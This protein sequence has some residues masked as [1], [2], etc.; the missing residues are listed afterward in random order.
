MMFFGKPIAAFTSD[1]R[2][3]ASGLLLL[4]TP[5][6]TTCQVPD[7]CIPRESTLGFFSKGDCVLAEAS[8]FQGHEWLTYFGNR[9]LRASE[10]FTRSEIQRI[11][12]GNRR[13]DWPKE[14]L[15]HLNASVVH[16][17]SALVEYTDR[18]ENQRLH[19]L[20]TD[21]NDTE[22]ARQDSLEHIQQLSV[23]ILDEWSQ[24]RELSLAMIGQANHTI[25]DS[26]SP[27]HTV[28]DPERDWCIV[29]CKAYIQ[30]DPDKLT[31]DIEFHGGEGGDT[32]GHTTT[33]DSIYRPGRDCADPRGAA[34]VEDCLSEPA[35]RARLATRDYLSLVRRALADHVVGDGSLQSA[36][37][38]IERRFSE[39]TEEHLQLCE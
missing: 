24:N 6:L 3:W 38:I 11:A 23:R 25:Q 2:R 12:E 18:P 13:V 22:Q 1:V 21:T 8:F 39:F 35:L 36:E 19:F 7:L 17:L 16:Y 37:A 15:V 34:E 32:I 4:A 26:F 29:K 31:D 9:D 5:L 20:L 14:L 30:R 27:A 10:R 33:E 28:R